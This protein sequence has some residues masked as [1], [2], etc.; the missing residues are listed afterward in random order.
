MA[1]MVARSKGAD[2][3]RPRDAKSMS[4]AE[5]TPSVRRRVVDLEVVQLPGRAVAAEVRGVLVELRRLEQLGQ[6]REVFVPHLLLDA[7]RAEGLD[8]ALDV[9]AGLVEGVA[10]RVTGVAA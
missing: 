3:R 9:D 8:R 10:E 5:T 7:V 4:I 1:W 6:F 2:S